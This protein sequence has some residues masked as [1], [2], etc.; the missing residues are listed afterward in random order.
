M[1]Y[2]R[3][4]TY[5][6]PFQMERTV[7]IEEAAEAL[8]VSRRTIY[9]RIRQ[10]RLRTVRT[11]NGSQRVLWSSIEALLAEPGGGRYR[12]K[13]TLTRTCNP[14]MSSSPNAAAAPPSNASGTQLY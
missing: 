6:T 3:G 1:R 13:S 5:M 11:R 9:Y 14:P 4:M 8:G 2:S 7:F 12:P 10:G